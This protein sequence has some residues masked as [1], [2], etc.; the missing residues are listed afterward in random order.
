MRPLKKGGARPVH[1]DQWGISERKRRR[2]RD[3]CSID[4]LKLNQGVPGKHSRPERSARLYFWISPLAP[5]SVLSACHWWFHVGLKTSKWRWIELDL[6]CQ[7]GASQSC[8]LLTDWRLKPQNSLTL[9]W[10]TIP[11]GTLTRGHYRVS[12]NNASPTE[13][14]FVFSFTAHRI[15]FTKHT[16]PPVW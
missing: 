12:V 15:N 2:G 10:Q 5:V 1:A 16:I 4:Y 3:V 11:A 8:V 9:V 6:Q 13:H 7:C 14:V